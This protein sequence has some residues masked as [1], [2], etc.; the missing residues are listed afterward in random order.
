MRQNTKW[1]VT[2][3]VSMGVTLHAAGASAQEPPPA[4]PP[5][6]PAV[7]GPA[8]PG[9]AAAAPADA[10]E[11]D[12]MRFRGGVNLA[13]GTLILEGYSGFL[14][15]VDGRVGLQINNL[16][17]VYA[18]PHLSFGPVTVGGPGVKATTAI[19]VFSATALA[20]ATLIDHIYVGGGGGFGV[21]N[22]PSGPVV[23]FR[24]GGY[25]LMG[26]GENGIRRKG[27][28]LGADMRLYILSGV[29]VMQMMGAVGYEAF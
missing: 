24:V 27:L 9:P 5:P 28:M 20:E 15:G 12:G 17:G 29:T 23:H 4:P 6:G 3:A 2:I 26:H 14:A 11:K 7:P 8:V 13:A 22:K 21:L 10:G 16:I 18:M 25:P 1:L 19:G